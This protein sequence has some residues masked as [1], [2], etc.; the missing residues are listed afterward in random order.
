MESEDNTGTKE[1]AEVQIIWQDIVS[2]AMKDKERA[3]K[4]IFIVTIVLIIVLLV[5][6]AYWIWTFNQYDYAS[7]TVEA[8]QDGDGINMAGGGNIIYGPEGQGDYDNENP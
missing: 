5:T 1:F 3:N 8:M 2:D 6:N 4:R 7:V